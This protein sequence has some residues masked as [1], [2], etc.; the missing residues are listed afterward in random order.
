[1]CTAT[2]SWG[3]GL[4][5]AAIVVVVVLTAACASARRGEGGEPSVEVRVSNNMVPALTVSILAATEGTTPV[6]LGT[7]VSG[8]EQTFTYR[9]TVTTGTFRLVADRPGPGGALVSEP[10]PLPQSGTMTVEWELQN[11]NV[12]VR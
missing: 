12:V 10:I 5:V 9:P 7:L 8:A 2:R 11:N 6:R 1:M 4:R 3:R